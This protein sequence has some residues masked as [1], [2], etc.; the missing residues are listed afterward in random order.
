MNN[1][2]VPFFRAPRLPPGP[3]W[4]PP[5]PSSGSADR[6]PRPPAGLIV[7]GA[8]WK[9]PGWPGLSSVESGRGYGVRSRCLNGM[10][11][12]APQETSTPFPRT[13]AKQRRAVVL[14]ST[15]SPRRLNLHT[16]INN[17]ENAEPQRMQRGM[18]VRRGR[19]E[20]SPHTGRQAD[21]WGSQ[22]FSIESDPFGLPHTTDDWTNRR[23]RRSLCRQFP[24][25]LKLKCNRRFLRY[26]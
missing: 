15:E 8:Q 23:K 3:P 20:Y 17:A 9:A 6:P 21:M 11:G 26:W 25:F 5:R 22:Q 18:I 24:L 13:T 4:L 1:S 7:A 12:C 2:S 10:P 14:R 16:T 19:S